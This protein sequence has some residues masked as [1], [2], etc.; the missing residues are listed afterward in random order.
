[1]AQAFCVWVLLGLALPSVWGQNFSC[2]TVSYNGVPIS[3]SGQTIAAPAIDFEDQCF[4]YA[5]TG[6]SCCE[7]RDALNVLNAHGLSFYSGVVGYMDVLPTC[8][9]LMAQQACS[10]CS[11]D[12]PTFYY[13]T[14]STAAPKIVLCKEFCQRLYD[15]CS[16]S[17]IFRQ[18]YGNC[19]DRESCCPYPSKTTGY[20]AC[21]A[22]NFANTLTMSWALLLLLVALLLATYQL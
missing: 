4:W 8:W 15:A 1:M 12:L 10:I 13:N 21:F 16:G 5:G 2:P 3:R 17:S 11:P 7:R 19:T 14:T 9:N 22:G 18:V 6:A 20:A